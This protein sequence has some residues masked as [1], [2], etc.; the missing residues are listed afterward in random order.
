MGKRLELRLV[1][2]YFGP[3]RGFPE[4]SGLG[5][6]NPEAQLGKSQEGE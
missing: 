2:K 3:E 6:P 1:K 5:E 4:V